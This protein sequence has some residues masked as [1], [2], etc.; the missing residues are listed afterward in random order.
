MEIGICDLFGNWKLGFVILNY[1]SGHSKWATTKR[2][3]AIVDAKRGA[4]FTKFAN[5]ITIAAR[6][7]GDPVSNFSLRMAIDKARSVNM[8]K[9]NIER[10]IKRGTGEAGGAMI[11]ELVYEGIGPAQSQFVVKCLTDSKNRA[12]AVIR[13]LFDR[14]GGS[15]GAVMWNF[16]IKGVVTI[17]NTEFSKF[18]ADDLE[19]E[20]IDLD[21]DDFI[22]E[23]EGVIIYTKPADLQ[24]VKQF[25]EKKNIATESA[26]IE[27]VAKEKKELTGED[28]AKF[29][30]F[31]DAIED[32]DEVAE[33]YTNVI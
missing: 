15:L 26:E 4:I 33:Y 28:K 22:K 14:F 8:P 21:I 25:L 16:A 30:K 20:L 24:K 9:E 3:K 18:N 5:V 29:E 13:H 23:D 11:E 27:Y 31:I 7:G 1:M 19:L 12:A 32:N 10:A 2:A 17:A 6:H